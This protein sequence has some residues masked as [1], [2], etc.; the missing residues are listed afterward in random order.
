MQQGQGCVSVCAEGAQN[1]EPHFTNEQVLLW[2]CLLMNWFPVLINT[3]NLNTFTGQ[4]SVQ[5]V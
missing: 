2:R 5:L 1:T 4:G 3:N